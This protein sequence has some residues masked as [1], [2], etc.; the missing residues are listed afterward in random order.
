MLKKKISGPDNEPISEGD[1]IEILVNMA[2]SYWHKAMVIINF[3][4]MQ[5]TLVEAVEYL[6]CLEY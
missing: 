4:S 2:P 5:R 1:L 3:E 6:A